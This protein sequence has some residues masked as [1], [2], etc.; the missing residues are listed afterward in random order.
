MAR[1][2]RGDTAKWKH[3]GDSGLV[4]IRADGEPAV[5]GFTVHREM[6]SRADQGPCRTPGTCGS[7]HSLRGSSHDMKR[8]MK[9]RLSE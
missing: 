8:D 3:R 4:Q 5:C 2:M 7:T 1:V 9:S 6:L